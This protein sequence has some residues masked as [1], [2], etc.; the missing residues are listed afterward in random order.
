MWNHLS[1]EKG[2]FSIVANDLLLSRLFF[3]ILIVPNEAL[4]K[5]RQHGQNV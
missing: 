3:M 5:R 4:K 2:N 1:K